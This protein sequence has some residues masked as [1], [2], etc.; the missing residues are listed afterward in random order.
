MLVKFFPNDSHVPFA[1]GLVCLSEKYRF[2][3]AKARKGNPA[4]ASCQVHSQLSEIR[5][6]VISIPRIRRNG[7]KTFDSCFFKSAAQDCSGGSGELSRAVTD[8]GLGAPEA[9]SARLCPASCSE[10]LGCSCQVRRE[11]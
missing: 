4:A 2:F 1:K 5:A 7:R 6:A 3:W 10:A 9:A 11:V 8:N